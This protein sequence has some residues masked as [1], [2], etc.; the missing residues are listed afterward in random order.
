V[1]IRAV[2][3]PF[4][5]LATP[6]TLNLHNMPSTSKS[7]IVASLF[8]TVF[9]TACGDSQTPRLSISSDLPPT[10]T[11]AA[12][13][14]K[15]TGSTATDST[16]LG[17]SASAS[18][19]A[20]DTATPQSQIDPAATSAKGDPRQWWES[21]YAYG[22][23]IG[24]GH[25]LI[26]DAQEDGRKL[27]KIDCQNH[28]A[29]DRQ[30]Q[31][32]II[33]ISNESMETPDGQLIRFHTEINSGASRTQMNGHVDNGRLIV[34]TTTA[35]KTSTE[36][37]PWVPGTLGF[38]ATEESLANSPLLPGTHRSVLALM[39]ATN[40]VVNIDLTADQ[41]EPTPLVDHTE[42]LLRIDS[43]I[44]LPIQGGNDHPLVMRSQLWANR[45]GQVLKTSL[46]ALHQETYR[47]TK[48]AAQEEAGA[49]R[50][51]LVV[52]NTVPVTQSL[53]NPHDT[54]RIKYRV[55]LVND[56]P[57]KAFYSGGSQQITSL[58]PHTAE[59]TV[60]RIDLSSTLGPVVANSARP[61]RLPTTEDRSPN[62]L[63]QSD[64]DQV[65]AMAKAVA[66]DETD[67]A[68]LALELEKYVNQIVTLK[69]FSQAFDTAAEVARQR[70]GDCTEH[71]VLLAA[72]ARARGIPARVAIG[73]VYQPATQSFQYHMWN[74]LWITD[75][76]VPMDATLGRGGIG[77]A[78]LKLTDSNLSGA[79]AYSCFLPVAQVIG[80]LK[81]EILEVE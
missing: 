36:S 61:P 69:N 8:L 63:I 25:T 48:S 53:T 80:Q 68:K 40:E 64:D 5:R 21:I 42:D 11:A 70:E 13:E 66:P 31:Q 37:F 59:I 54:R 17:A 62:N 41:Y 75:H 45:E 56:D 76:W 43:T 52:D 24:W 38:N 35:G 77:A 71:A 49:R 58:N 2:I 33:D 3:P 7:C 79:Q 26:S 60:R 50:L 29:V 65:L 81:I 20:T 19:D 22:K 16:P 39:P 14:S 55:Q 12:P 15:T 67:P 74:E 47:T 57:A 44:T 78:H 32:T 28:I 10:T 6:S 4:V 9:L 72:L 51:D 18:T 30:G 27:A 23:K 73:L 46:V 34:E 1:K